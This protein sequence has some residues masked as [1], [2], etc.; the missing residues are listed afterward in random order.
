M[1]H[2]DRCRLLVQTFQELGYGYIENDKRGF[3][4]GKSRD[5][6]DCDQGYIFYPDGLGINKA[7]NY[8]MFRGYV[9]D[10]ED[11]YYLRVN[12]PGFLHGLGKPPLVINLREL[13][14]NDDLSRK[15]ADFCAT[16]P[17]SAAV[18]ATLM[19]EHCQRTRGTKKQ[20]VIPCKTCDG[21]GIMLR[22]HKIDCKV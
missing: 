8:Q 11:I 21:T 3:F 13:T 10:N 15:I 6:D 1:N 20:K 16:I 5:P 2:A 22:H 12:I 7:H 14:C 17:V 18:V 9:H 19:T 4:S